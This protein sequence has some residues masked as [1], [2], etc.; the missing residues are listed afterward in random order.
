MP[1]RASGRVM[2]Q[3]VRHGLSPE[4]ARDLLQPRV[5]RGEADPR[6]I[7][8]IRRGDEQHRHHDAGERAPEFQSDQRLE[9][10]AQHA[11]P[12]E[13]HQAARCRRPYAAPQAADRSARRLRFCRE[14]GARQD[15]SQRHAEQAASVAD[16]NAPSR[17]ST[18]ASRTS[19]MR[20]TRRVRPRLRKRQ[21]DER[22][23]Q[24][25][26]STGCRE[27]STTDKARAG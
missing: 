25:T 19:A 18:I 10:L 12:A 2:R 6:R 5:D 21:R 23:D 7:H 27:T 4:R 13:H 15:V 20:A 26:P 24:E 3:K 14:I 17:L 9:R 8:R 1:R 16:R 11:L 22:N